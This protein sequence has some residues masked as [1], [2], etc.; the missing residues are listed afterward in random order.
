MFHNY[1]L[2][3]LAILREFFLFLIESL[4]EKYNLKLKL[5]QVFILQK[6]DGLNYGVVL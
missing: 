4:L 6:P 1:L 2:I 3:C 5:S